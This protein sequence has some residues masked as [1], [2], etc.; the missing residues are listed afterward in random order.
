M[1]KVTVEITNPGEK[2]GIKASGGHKF[3]AISWFVAGVMLKTAVLG[4]L[5][6]T[7]HHYAL[8]GS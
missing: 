2:I 1:T 5:W 6:Y 4:A 7:A 3:E 8:R